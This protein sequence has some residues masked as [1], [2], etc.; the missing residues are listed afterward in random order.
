[1]ARDYEEQADDVELGAAVQL[2]NAETLE[3]AVDGD[4]L[5]AGYIPP[6]RPFGLEEDNV[7]TAGM[8]EGDSLDERLRRENPEQEQEVDP[9]RAGRLTIVG[10]GAGLETANALEGEDVGIDGAAASAEEAAM[11]EYPVDALRETEPSMAGMLTDPE[12]DAQL[13][14]DPDTSRAARIDAA[15]DADGAAAAASGLDDVGSGSGL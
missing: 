8:L 14:E 7:T 15:R 4:A 13:G 1:M 10:E 11:H 3:G 5:D 12:L 6:D 2:D 9:D